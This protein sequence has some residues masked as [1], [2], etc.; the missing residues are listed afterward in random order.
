M[1]QPELHPRR[2][3]RGLLGLQCCGAPGRF[4]DTLDATEGEDGTYNSHARLDRGA[5]VAKAPF[6][7]T[8]LGEGQKAFSLLLP[9]IQGRDP[10]PH[11][12]QRHVAVDKSSGSASS[13]RS[14]VAVWP[15]DTYPNQW[16]ATIMPARS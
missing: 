5:T 8:T 10:R 7:R 3:R 16:R 2:P 15:A 13:H 6:I 11:Q 1:P 12:E 4:G 14:T 9:A